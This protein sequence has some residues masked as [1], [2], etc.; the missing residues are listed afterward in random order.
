MFQGRKVKQQIC[1]SCGFTKNT[2]DD[3]Y[4]LSLQVK[5]KTGVHD[6]L[7]GMLLGDVINDWKCEACNQKV[8]L[9][10]IEMLADTPNVLIVHLQRICFSFE[11]FNNVKINSSFDFPE[12][13]DLRP[14]SFGELMRRKGQT[15]DD[16][17]TD[18]LKNLF[19]VDSDEYIYRLVG[20]NI[21]R[22][23]GTHGHYWSL[24]NTQR[25][26]L[27]KDPIANEKEWL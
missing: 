1:K 23:T 3:F 25:G 2:L 4:T 22:G 9:H 14:Y 5:N 13:L 27:E 8:D 19:N 15:E 11:T 16:F 6:S 12:I 18:A 10:Q 26:H 17:N 20:V 21:H 7:K 24:I